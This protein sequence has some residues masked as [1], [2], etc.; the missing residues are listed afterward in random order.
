MTGI[1]YLAAMREKWFNLRV[2]S[3]LKSN[4]IQ[5]KCTN[6]MFKCTFTLEYNKHMWVIRV[7]STNEQPM[8]GK[9]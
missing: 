4:P 1:V 3:Y 6:E 2:Y 5:M 7:Y 8:Y 9:K